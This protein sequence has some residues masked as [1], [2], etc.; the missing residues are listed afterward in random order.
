MAAIAIAEA[1]GLDEESLGSRIVWID[2]R[3][4]EDEIVDAVAAQVDEPLG[5][6][7]VDDALWVHW[8]GE[9]RRL[10]LTG[11]PHDRYVALGSLAA[12]LGGRYRFWL[13]EEHLQ[14]DTHGLLVTRAGGEADHLA[15]VE[16]GGRVFVP[17][18]PGH[19]YFHG[20]DVPC[21]GTDARGPD[22]ARHAA[23]PAAARRES[24]RDL[25]AM[26]ADDP[27]FR[28][29]MTELRREV[30]A[31]GARP[32]LRPALRYGVP[33]LVAAWLAWRWFGSGA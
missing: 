8:D 9:R 33:V 20:I 5:A 30:G 27:G 32:Y 3:A 23:K 21:L 2:H 14:D 22:F 4:C 28:S 12:W 7:W 1:T 13:A 15:T 17:L 10:P 29:K 16:A 18:R 31:E 24:Q 11:T 25:I 26:L 19:D 6:E